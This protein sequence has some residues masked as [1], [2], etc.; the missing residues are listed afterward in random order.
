M[1]KLILP[2]KPT[3]LTAAKERQLTNKF[4]NEQ[5]VVWKYKYIYQPIRD[6]S[7][8]KCCFS[9]LKLNTKSTYLEIEHFYPKD[10]YPKEVVSWGNLLPSCKKCNT[11]KGKTNTKIQQIIHPY[12]D[13]PKEHLYFEYF[14]LYPKN[15]SIKGKNTIEIT[16]LNDRNHFVKP[17]SEQALKF[18][19]ELNS[20][21]INFIEEEALL[22]LSPTKKE[23]KINQLKGILSDINRKNEFSACI[24]TTVFDSTDYTNIKSFLSSH[25][26]WDKELQSFEKEILFCY[27]GK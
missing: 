3:K 15:G 19:D 16:A 25:N 12:T 22:S 21:Y 27:L 17:R 13:D 8:S 7:F 1:I 5:K 11:T 26:L 18:L 2:P 23:Q 24:S 9:E 6:A 14:R 4:I 20:F 10:T